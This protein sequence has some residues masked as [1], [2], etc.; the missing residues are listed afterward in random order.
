MQEQQGIV[1]LASWDDKKKSCYRFIL[2]GV[3]KNTSTV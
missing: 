2:S 3:S 1:W